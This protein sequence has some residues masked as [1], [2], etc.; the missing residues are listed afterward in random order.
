MHTQSGP[1]TIRSI[2]YFPLNMFSNRFSIWITLLNMERIRK[3]W[4]EENM[5]FI[6]T[7][8][9][10]YF[11]ICIMALLGNKDSFWMANCSTKDIKRFDSI[12][13]S[14]LGGKWEINCKTDKPTNKWLRDYQYSI[15]YTSIDI[16]RERKSL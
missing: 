3:W 13:T 11:I 1:Y 14:N 7:N 10:I 6:E 12:T 5:Q 9:K 4:H 15:L 16:R 2:P 8:T